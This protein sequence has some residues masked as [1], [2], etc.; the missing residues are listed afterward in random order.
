MMSRRIVLLFIDCVSVYYF[1]CRVNDSELHRVAVDFGFDD[2]GVGVDHDRELNGVVGFAHLVLVQVSAEHN[3]GFSLVEDR[4]EFI[5]DVN[6]AVPV[7]LG[8][9]V[10]DDNAEWSVLVLVAGDY[11]AQPVGLL[12]AVVVIVGNAV[13]FNIGVWFI[14][15]G[16]E[17][18]EINGSLAESVVDFVL[19]RVEVAVEL[20]GEV[21]SRLVVASDIINGDVGGKK[22][23]GSVHESVKHLLLIVENR[24]HVA[25]ENEKIGALEVALTDERL[26]ILITTVDIVDDAEVDSRAAAVT[27][28]EGASAVWVGGSARAVYYHITLV[29]CDLGRIGTV[30]VVGVGLQACDS[31]DVDARGAFNAAIG[32]VVALA[33]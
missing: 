4:N 33:R 10:A 13:I 26:E 9:H 18:D 2:S 30:T 31:D 28:L 7:V 8:R 20:S 23:D 6:L 21:A 25:V 14:L 27:R 19:G 22:F 17:H 24:H 11:S 32:V 5:E 12:G 16:V 3:V 15:A 1:A 29:A